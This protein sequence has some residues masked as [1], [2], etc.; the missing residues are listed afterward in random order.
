MRFRARKHLGKLQMELL[1]RLRTTVVAAAVASA[2]GAESG[3]SRGDPD[4]RRSP[5]TRSRSSTRGRSVTL[6]A[7]VRESAW[8]QG[9]GFRV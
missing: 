6:P 8:V 5:E 3:C 4:P 2:P 1:R 9:I 7:S